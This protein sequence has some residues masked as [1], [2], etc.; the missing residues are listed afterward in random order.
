MMS[1]IKFDCDVKAWFLSG[2]FVLSLMPVAAMAQDVD[3]RLNRL[4]NEMSTLGRAVYRGETPPPPAEFSG[5]G[6]GQAAADAQLKVQGLEVELRKLNGVLEEKDFEIR[7]L[8]NDFQKA[9]QDLILRV[10][11][12]EAARGVSASPTEIA[13]RAAVQTLTAPTVSA[14][15]AEKSVPKAQVL[16]TISQ[17]DLTDVTVPAQPDVRGATERYQAAFALLKDGKYPAAQSAFEGFLADHES[18][19]LAGNAQYW[20]GE[21]HYVR[22]N[23]DQASQA[24]AKGFKEYPKGSKAPDNLL[25]LGITLVALDQKDDA[26]VALGQVEK[27]FSANGAQSVLRRAKLE[28]ERIACP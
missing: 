14:L 17:N 27:E 21:T 8:R 11:D 6:S 1:F 2:L 19:S 22:G 26:C 12:L 25:K 9:N 3:S 23:Y 10:Q 24:F 28:M 5:V 13:P 15:A 20:L 4:E 16:G 7:T 18:H